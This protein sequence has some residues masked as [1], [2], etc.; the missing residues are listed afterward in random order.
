MKNISKYSIS[1]T[2]ILLG[3]SSF[4]QKTCVQV[5]SLIDSLPIVKVLIINTLNEKQFSTSTNGEVCFDSDTSFYMAFSK[6]GFFEKVSFIKKN[7]LNKIYLLP[8]NIYLNDFVVQEK[9]DK[10]SLNKI[11]L[12]KN[13][14]MFVYH[15]KKSEKIILEKQEVNKSTN[16]TRQVYGLISGLNSIQTS[17]SGIGTEIGVRGLSSERSSNLNI[18]QNGYD[19]S[20]DALGYPDA[21][22][23]PPV[24]T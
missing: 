17:S 23:V 15:A 24:H 10:F 18:R 14:D 11:Q 7:S 3:L 20:A 16:N 1:I 5:F 2:L 6:N 12:Y 9:L 13:E 22:Y 21:Y 19:I 8:T 4:G